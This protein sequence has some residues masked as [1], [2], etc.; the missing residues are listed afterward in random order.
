M[1][2]KFLRLNKEGDFQEV[3][4]LWKLMGFLNTSLKTSYF[5]SEYLLVTDELLCILIVYVKWKS[6]A[7]P[8]ITRQLQ[9][10]FV[11]NL[12]FMQGV[13]LIGSTTYQS[14][15]KFNL[16]D[17]LKAIK[18]QFVC[19]ALSFFRAAKPEKLIIS[20]QDTRFPEWANGIVG[21]GHIV[22]SKQ[23]FTN[24]QVLYREICIQ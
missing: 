24:I 15:V 12:Q 7:L 21:E 17:C 11:W 5:K 14:K 6:F 20:E 1:I 8:R 3:I 9:L 23:P 13:F 16:P 18:V 2:S 22:P 4:I 19:E 10:S